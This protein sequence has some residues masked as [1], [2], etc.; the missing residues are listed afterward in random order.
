MK[1]PG[2]GASLALFLC[3]M[4]PFTALAQDA[5]REQ[6]ISTGELREQVR[7]RPQ[8]VVV[9]VEITKQGGKVVLQT[10]D[11]AVAVPI[12]MRSP[13]RYGRCRCRPR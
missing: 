8:G 6:R 9:P 7:R 3:C 5:P 4:P 11:S 2:F 1:H 10:A 13:S 12:P